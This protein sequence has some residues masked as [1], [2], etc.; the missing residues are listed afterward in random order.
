MTDLRRR[1]LALGLTQGVLSV[2]SEVSHATISRVENGQ[3]TFTPEAQARVER[4]LR[5]LESIASGYPVRLDFRN[6]AA[7]RELLQHRPA[8]YESAQVAATP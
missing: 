2:L 3:L 1:R 4:V 5:D 8:S 6:P 7:V